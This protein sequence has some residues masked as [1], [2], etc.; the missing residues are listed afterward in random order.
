MISGDPGKAGLYV[1]RLQA[2]IEAAQVRASMHRQTSAPA[3]V[4]WRDALT[5]HKKKC[6]STSWR[7]GVR[8]VHW[9]R[10]E[11]PLDE[12]SVLLRLSGATCPA[13]EATLIR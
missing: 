1:V 6:S 5:D 4:G 12:R 10:D 8:G 11:E 9:L 3:T 13:G 7:A 2:D